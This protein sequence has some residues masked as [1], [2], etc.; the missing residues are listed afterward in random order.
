[1]QGL[2]PRLA[3]AKEMA[4]VFPEWMESRLA[5]V[6]TP[7]LVLH[8]L[9]DKITDPQM[10]QRLH[11]EAAVSDKSIKLYDG[12]FHCELLCCLPGNACFIGSDWLPEQSAQTEECLTDV[13]EWLRARA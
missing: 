5:E 1:M 2:P 8:G 12:A 9:S 10:S 13:A 6:R 4:F 7:F 3:S 11:K